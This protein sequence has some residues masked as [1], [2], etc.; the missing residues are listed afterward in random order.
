[1]APLT[2]VHLKRAF[3]VLISFH[4]L[5]IA[6]SNYLVQIPFQI[7]SFNTTWGTFSFP[8]VYLATDLTVRIFGSYR[9]R[10]IIFGA[11][12]P[13]L[14][15]SYVVSIL[16]FEGTFQGFTEL[17]TFN[18]FVFRIAFASFIAYIVGQILDITVFSY[19]RRQQK[20]WVAPTVSTVVG[21][22]IDTAVFY[23][24]CLHGKLRYLYGNPLA[25]NRDCRL[26]F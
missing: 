22:L 2:A 7:V 9:A 19:L 15:V 10:N 18:I 13:A 6:A 24:L 4:I 26:R 17:K 12:L 21:N 11:M 16:F 3:I 8:F 1:M 23:S 25:R 5:I 14:V 20:W